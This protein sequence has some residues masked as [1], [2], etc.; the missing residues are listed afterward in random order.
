RGG[1]PEHERLIVLP[2]PDCATL[3]MVGGQGDRDSGYQKRRGVLGVA[4]I[5][6]RTG[7]RAIAGPQ[8]PAWPAHQTTAR[9]PSD[10]RQQPGRSATSSVSRNL[11]RNARSRVRLT[12]P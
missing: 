2:L 1:R 3:T 6:F 11:R 9:F 5:D 4:E 12:K 8:G 10:P 7:F